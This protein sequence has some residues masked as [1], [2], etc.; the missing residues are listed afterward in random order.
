MRKVILVIAVFLFTSVA[1]Q[2]QDLQESRAG[3]RGDIAVELTM[4][5]F[6]DSEGAWFK[7]GYLRGRY[8]FPGNNF[9]VRLGLGTDMLF[10]TD[11]EDRTE[12]VKNLSFFDIRPG[13]EYYLGRT[14]KA[15]PFVGIDLIFTNL[16]T[17]FDAS[18]GPPIT[19]AWDIELL[20]NRGYTAFGF[21]IFAG[22]DYFLGNGSIYIGTEIGM[23][24]LYFNN[25]EVKW[26][27]DVRYPESKTAQFRP[28]LS[29]SVRIGIV[30]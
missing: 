9:G 15:L 21:N 13:M 18:V 1:V 20:E 29:S 6:A 26:G 7:A 27:D 10:H 11:Q 30:F 17:S 19:G 23:E 12:T 24:F 25:H 2:A 5:P 8:F 14:D 3:G 28:N 4:D 16:N 22:G